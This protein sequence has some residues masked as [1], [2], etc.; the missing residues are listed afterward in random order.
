MTNDDKVGY[1]RPPT[2]SRFTK[3]KSGN[4]SG[5]PKTAPSFK[6]DLAAE[7]QQPREILENGYLPPQ[8]AL[9]ARA[10]AAAL[11]ATVAKAIVK[12]VKIALGT[13]SSVFAHGRNGEEFAQMM[14]DAFDVLY[15]EGKTS[16]RVMGICLHPFIT[17]Q[18]ARRQRHHQQVDSTGTFGRTGDGRIREL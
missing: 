8:I 2:H 6:S 4:R 15:E 5:R 14:R 3:G 12:Q 9:K 7:L 18:P 17:G 11:D 13:D 1:G 16:A 10:A